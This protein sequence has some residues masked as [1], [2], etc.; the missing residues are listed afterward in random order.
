MIV[1]DIF[2]NENMVETVGAVEYGC[3]HDYP[4]IIYHYYYFVI[5]TTNDS[6]RFEYTENKENDA[7]CDQK[8]A[9]RICDQAA[10]KVTKCSTN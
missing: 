2:I 6:Y 1:Q 3:N 10:R 8:R 4:G 5:K 9:A 7:Q